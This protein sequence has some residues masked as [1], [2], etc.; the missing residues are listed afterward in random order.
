[1]KISSH[2]A[3]SSDGLV[4]QGAS[5]NPPG[6]N[7]DQNPQDEAANPLLTWNGDFSKVQIPLNVPTI[8]PRPHGTPIVDSEVR[9]GSE[10]GVQLEERGLWGV[11]MLAHC[12]SFAVRYEGLV[13]ECKVTI[14]QESSSKESSW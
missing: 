2:A 3:Q 6:L 5:C 14:F 1:M 10:E 4:I 11:A 7:L 8:G 13:R 12:W 9:P